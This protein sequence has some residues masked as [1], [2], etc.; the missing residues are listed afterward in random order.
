MLSSKHDSF[1]QYDIP[2]ISTRGDVDVPIISYQST[3]VTPPVELSLVDCIRCDKTEVVT[4]WDI[5]RSLG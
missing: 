2:F 1:Q 4:G 5:L 3:H